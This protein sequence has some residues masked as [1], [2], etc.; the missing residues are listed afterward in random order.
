V[1]E[2]CSGN[3]SSLTI[4][5][6]KTSSQ[7]SS[8]VSN[9]RNIIYLVGVELLVI[10]TVFVTHSLYG[11]SRTGTAIACSIKVASHV[12]YSSTASSSARQDT[13]YRWD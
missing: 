2:L 5:T 4:R 6:C 8:I 9:T 11:T 1:P 12:V 10:V 3:Y 7:S 13:S